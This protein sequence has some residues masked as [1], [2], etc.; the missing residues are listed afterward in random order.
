MQTFRLLKLQLA[1]AL[2]GR[3]SLA[4]KEIADRCGFENSLN[5]ARCFTRV[6]GKSPPGNA[7]VIAQA[8]SPTTEPVATGYLAEDLLVKQSTQEIRM[9]GLPR[10]PR[11]EQ[12]FT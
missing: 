11:K 8:G 7:G 6:Y 12:V 4:I 1:M 9:L 10:L 5:F 3:S 2:L